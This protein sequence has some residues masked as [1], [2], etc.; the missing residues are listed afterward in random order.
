MAFWIRQWGGGDQ[1]YRDGTL[2]RDHM[3]FGKKASKGGVLKVK[4]D[5]R[6]IVT[7]VATHGALFAVETAQ[8][9]G[10]PT[11]PSEQKKES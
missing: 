11:G 2:P 6:L 9:D 5:D 1:P 10:T 4:K 8:S 7:G 3:Q